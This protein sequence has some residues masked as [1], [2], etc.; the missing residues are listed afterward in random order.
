MTA[1]MLV[2]RVI[3]EL[4]VRLAGTK[5]ELPASRR[6]RALLGWL[7]VHPGRH[8]RSRLAGL[9]WPEVLDASARASLRS[10]LWALR[11][12]L[13][14]GFAAYLST[15]R[16]SQALAGAGLQVDLLEVRR[17]L[18]AGS[19]G[20]A[21]ELCRGELLQEFDDEWVLE[22]REDFDRDVAGALAQLVTR[23]SAAG[24]RAGAV[25]WARRRAALCPLD[26]SA[27]A[28]LIRALVEADDVPAAREAF[29]RLKQRLDSELGVPVS[30]QTAALIGAAPGGVGLQ[31]QVSREHQVGQA[32]Q[33]SRGQQADREHQTGQDQ[34]A[35]GQQPTRRPAETAAPTFHGRSGRT[36]SRV[37]TA[38]DA[39]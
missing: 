3:G 34:L 38:S 7:A 23:A 6:A 11:S 26:E 19:P 28:G 13:G 37:Q 32:P 39:R 20:A 12:S 22:A 31:G 33:T 2:I 27:G 1:A 18:A 15:E 36:G 9:F 16:D 17:L 30:A 35:G 24:D 5:A 4:D 10:A 21:V 29:A 14:P 25:A 8:S